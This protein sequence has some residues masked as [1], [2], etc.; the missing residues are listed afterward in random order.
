M[1]QIYPLIM[2]SVR[3]LNSLNLS[4]DSTSECP[5]VDGDKVT[6][7]ANTISRTDPFLG[8]PAMKMPVASQSHRWEFQS[9]P[10]VKECLKGGASPKSSAPVASIGILDNRR[11]SKQRETLLIIKYQCAGNDDRI[12]CIRET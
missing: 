6:W 9:I 3:R 4:M 5:S 11:P 12:R 1:S 2:P 8:E 10:Q 7:T